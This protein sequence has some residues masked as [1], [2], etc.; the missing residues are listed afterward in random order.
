MT[1]KGYKST[2]FSIVRPHYHYDENL[3]HFNLARLCNRLD[4]Q[5]HKLFHTVLDL[6]HRMHALLP[7]RHKA[8]VIAIRLKRN[9]KE[10]SVCSL[11][12]LGVQNKDIGTASQ[13]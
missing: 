8:K 12:L 11:S 10:T 2:H 13:A 1:L 6:S 5:C 4:S 7:S 3:T 9:L